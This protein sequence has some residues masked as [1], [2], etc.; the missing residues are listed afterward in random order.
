MPRLLLAWLIVFCAVIE[1]DAADHVYVSVA[2]ENRIALYACDPSEGT[3]THRGDTLVDGQPG[4]LASDPSH[5]YLF[6]SIRSTGELTSFRI[7]P[8]GALTLVSKVPA[9]ADPAYVA[10]DRTGNYLLSAYYRAGKVAVHAIDEAGRLSHEPL[11]TIPTDEKA[12]AI[13]TDPSNHFVFVP[14]TGPNAIYQFLFDAETGTLTPNTPAKVDT[15]DNTGPRHLAF[16]PTEPLA[17]VDNEQ[18]SS[19]TP[20]RLDTTTGRLS[21]IERE[22]FSTIPHEF[23]ERNSCARLQIHPTGRFLYAAN[24]GHD[25]IAGFR[26]NAEKGQLHGLGQFPTEATPR[27]FDITSDGNFLIAAGQSSGKLATY[28]I[29]PDTGKLSPLATLPI[30]K[31]PWWVQTV[32]ATEQVSIETTSPAWPNWMGPNHDGI[33]H[34][35]GWST[36]WPSSGL[37]VVWSR[38]IGVG[39]S[40]VSIADGRL[41][42][43]GHHSGGETVWALDAATGE[44]LWQ[45]EYRGALLPNL[46]EG[47]PASTPTIDGDFVYTLGKEGQFYCLR[48]DTGETVWEHDL[49]RVLGVSTPEW[50]FSSS[51]YILGDQLILEAGRVVSFNKKTGERIWQTERHEAG[52]GSAA[53]LEQEGRSLLAT[54][55]CDGLRITDSADGSHVAFT[56]WESP[57]RT[58]STTP[59]V[60]GNRIYISTGYNVGCGLFRFENNQLHQEYANRE[61]RNHFNNSILYDGHLY[62]FDGNSNLGRVVQ[63]KCMNLETGKVAWVQRGFG[64]GSLMIADGKLLI[65]SDKGTLALAEASP[66]G[67]QELARSRFLEGRCWTVPVLLDGYVYGRNA[68]GKLTCVTLPRTRK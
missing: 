28:R 1:T 40:S 48:A 34:E 7:A 58:N 42:T 61:M 52:Y 45:H 54:L 6:A 68:A 47:G 16:H 60:V 35:T 37:P 3:L 14:H 44:V 39:F 31:A 41:F 56:A 9:G 18:G 11:Q 66:E 10:T 67:Y 30:G 19:V 13:L 51:P 33:S 32:P 57:F 2:Q 8:D 20:F 29:D 64:C 24:R 46:H 15:R 5:Q 38:E 43:M 59:I 49:R 36:D 26:I 23:E 55:D 27:G 22:T 12:H 17:F 25:S 4:A 62:G 53:L 50:G 65:L 63:L 21:E